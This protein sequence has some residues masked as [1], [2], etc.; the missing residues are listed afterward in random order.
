[1]K[2]ALVPLALATVTLAVAAAS[3]RCG[4]DVPTPVTVRV[5]NTL[6]QGLWVD[7]TR[8]LLGV[9]LQRSGG[10]GGWQTFRE[11]LA[12]DCERCEQV[13]GC[14][15]DAGNAPPRVVKVAGL[16]SAEREWAGTIQEPGEVTCGSI[17]GG[18]S[19][20]RPYIPSLDEKLRARLCYALGPPIG[21]AD[22]GD[23]GIPVPGALDPASLLCVAAEFRPVDGEVELTPIL[24]SS[25][26][27]H[28]QCKQD[29]GELCFEGACTTSCPAHGFPEYG[30]TWLV[31]V[32]AS[33][34][35]FF[36]TTTAGATTVSEGTGT[37]TDV[38]I[39]NGT[40]RLSLSRPAAGGGNVI[41]SV[42][43]TVPAAYFPVLL[44]SETLS[45][46]VVDAST[47]RIPYNRAISVRDS[48]GRLL[49][50]VD[51]AIPGAILGA[52]DT[53]PFS[54]SGTGQIVG[55]DLQPCGKR[56]HFRTAFGGATTDAG[57]V[58]EL[59]P[60]GSSTVVAGGLTYKLLNLVNNRPA[61]ICSAT[62]QMTYLVAAQR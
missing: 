44:R 41:A 50:A 19:C 15:C 42:Y 5:K 12:C 28:D 1:M 25:C 53:A 27:S 21:T 11:A 8:G 34:Q 37:L 36:T 51:P 59:D 61:S 57:A 55:C 22:P 60:G 7:Q 16:G 3:C 33:D 39:N 40:M 54:V 45:V 49:L 48:A 20:F 14:T 26:Q 31:A 10:V 38:Q 4:G 58:L 2:P 13:C 35:G 23:A 9:E 46:K 17:F 56:L 6:P 52:A 32:S 24:G 18:R 43:L 30:T 62:P 47:S 29:G